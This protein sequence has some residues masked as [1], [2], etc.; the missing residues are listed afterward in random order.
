MNQLAR[1]WSNLRGATMLTGAVDR[2]AKAFDIGQTGRRLAAIPA[3]SV[4]LNTLIQRYGRT[5]VARSRYLCTNNPYAVAARET[6]V[7]SIV[8]GAGIRPSTLGETP[9]VKTQVHDDWQYW[10]EMADAEGLSNFSGL[11]ST[12]A[13]EMFEAG[14]FF[15]QFISN[16]NAEADEVPMLVRLIPSEMLPFDN[17][18]T[19]GVGKGNRI[20]MGIEFD[21]NGV[22]VAYHFLTINPTDITRTDING[23]T[24]ARVLAADVCH[25]F[26]PLRAGQIRGIPFTLSA[27]V[28]T[29][30][31]D[32]YDDAELERKRVAA[33]FAAFVT[34]ESPEAEDSPLGQ[35]SKVWGQ[36]HSDQNEAFKLQPGMVV[37]LLPGENITFSSPADVGASYDPFEY[38]MLCRLAAGF[39][40]PYASMSGDLKAANYGSIR[41][42][43]VQFRRRIE[44]MQFQNFIPMFLRRV[45]LRWLLEYTK[46]GLSPWTAVDWVKNKRLHQKVKWLCPRWDWVDPMK[47]AQAEKLMVDNGFKS[48]FDTVE[49][50][51]YDPDETDARILEAQDSE[52]DND[53][54]LYRFPSG[55]AAADEVSDDPPLGAPTAPS[56]QENPNAQ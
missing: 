28:S 23:Y 18:S 26:R 47:D 43:L 6:F 51:G 1:L 10:C 37:D 33:L 30:M 36:N 34:K 50:M 24:R 31:L 14:E 15:A 2:V 41:A 38:R 35:P 53:I 13:A 19:T 39:G 9:E 44:A 29:A 56:P 27:L 42:G 48:R 8:G 22:R 25:V 20:Q 3:A 55:V 45:W 40:V 4:A 49:E 11:Q 54:R 7:S 17:Y 16:P 21:P 32:L 12:G 5:A 52:D 46:K